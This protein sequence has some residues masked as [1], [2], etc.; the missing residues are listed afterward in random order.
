MSD[1]DA[2][3]LFGERAASI[4]PVVQQSQRPREKEDE[5]EAGEEEANPEVGRPHA[6]T[7]K[8]SQSVASRPSSAPLHSAESKDGALVGC[9][10]SVRQYC[11]SLFVDHQAEELARL[12]ANLA[13]RERQLENESRERER[14][15]QAREMAQL[16]QALQAAH[17]QAKAER[18][19]YDR[20]IEAANLRF[21]Q[22][23][24]AAEERSRAER[25][26]F[27][28]ALRAAEGRALALE[29]KWTAAQ[30]NLDELQRNQQFAKE[31]EERSRVE[32]DRR[33]AEA[34]RTLELETLR[35]Q[36]RSMKEVS[37]P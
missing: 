21:Q 7:G 1:S 20:A 4:N 32:R 34:R 14:K 29:A 18:A 27:D 12:K 16:Q 24:L 36:M 26:E 9:L 30:A 11:A 6:S 23:F 37:R 10:R 8:F 13:E 35:E 31:E 2:D 15:R 22:S 33:E 3:T 17:D 28:K 25:A 19:D 5:E